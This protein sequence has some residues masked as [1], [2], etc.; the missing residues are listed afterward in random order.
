MFVVITEILDKVRC[1][2]LETQNIS[3]A[4]SAFLLQVERRKGSNNSGG[5]IRKSQS[6]S[7]CNVSVPTRVGSYSP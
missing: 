7:D 5:P 2:R 1:L 4:G 6:Q 3:E